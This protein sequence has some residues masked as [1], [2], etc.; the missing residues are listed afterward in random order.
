MKVILCD[1][2]YELQMFN[3]LL[4]EQNISRN[5]N[6][7]YSLEILFISSEEVVTCQVD[8]E[9]SHKFKLG[10]SLIFY[11]TFFEYD[12]LNIKYFLFYQVILLYY[13]I[14]IFLLGRFLV[15]TSISN[16]LDAPENLK[17]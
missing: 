1:N 16:I 15:S 12:K 7:N 5:T 11:K 6:T 17:L 4:N 10:K 9:T 3:L 8:K 2:H 14:F 13:S